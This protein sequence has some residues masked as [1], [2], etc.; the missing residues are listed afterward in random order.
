MLLIICRTD[1]NKKWNKK[2]KLHVEKTFKNGVIYWWCETTQG[3][4]TTVKMLQQKKWPQIAGKIE[5]NLP[6]SWLVKTCRYM[7]KTFSR[8]LGLWGVQG[9]NQVK[10]THRIGTDWPHPQTVF[11]WICVV[12][13]WPTDSAWMGWEKWKLW[14]DCFSIPVIQKTTP[15]LRTDV[16]FSKLAV[17]TSVVHKR[18]SG[19]KMCAL[20]PLLLRLKLSFWV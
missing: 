8:P 13:W 2:I 16:F 5:A 20:S 12:G 11:S 3:G 15:F 6:Q 7:Q 10:L 9:T 1:L 19:I 4:V 17:S 18:K 14:N